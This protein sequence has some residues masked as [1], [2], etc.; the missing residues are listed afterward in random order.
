MPDVTEAAPEL[1]LPSPLVAASERPCEEKSR[2]AAAGQRYSAIGE[3]PAEP[4][5]EEADQLLEDAGGCGCF[6]WRHALLSFVVGAVISCHIM[7]M[8]YVH[9][10]REVT[11]GSDNCSSPLP[12]GADPDIDDW[13]DD[14]AK[15]TA[16]GWNLSGPSSIVGEW[17]L[18]C[19]R[20]WLVP[21]SDSL[22][23]LGWLLGGVFCGRVGD[24]HG[25][26]RP[27]VAYCLCCAAALAAT[28]ATRHIEAFI[29]CK[30]VHGFFTG[31]VLLS[32]Y[33]YGSE[34]VPAG[35]SA[36]H[37]TFYF[38]CAAAG[39]ATLAA[40]AYALRDSWRVFSLVLSGATVALIPWPLFSP[41]SPLW[42]LSLGREAEARA[43]LA[44]VARANGAPT[45]SRTWSREDDSVD[46]AG[47]LALFSDP[48]IRRITLSM[49]FVWLSASLC[50]FGLGL[51]GATLPGDAYVNG[52][53]LSVAELPV[54][55]LQLYCVDRPRLG[56]K[57]TMIGALL[58]GALAC[59]PGTLLPIGDAARW[60]AF[61]GNM[62][63]TAAF[64]TT[65]I[66]AAE[67][68]PADVRA[69]G[70]GVCT[71]GGKLGSVAT[72]FVVYLGAGSLSLAMII[73]GAVA[74]AGSLVACSLPETFG[75]VLP[76]TLAQLLSQEAGSP[77]TAKGPAPGSRRATAPC[78]TTRPVSLLPLPRRPRSVV[79]VSLSA[80]RGQRDSFGHPWITG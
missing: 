69:S 29:L 52:A 13:C 44:V 59:C 49:A 8:Y 58:V 19:G 1:R 53:L 11:C 28:A 70:L 63:M 72:P 26:R 31:P 33:V 55:P 30:F 74:A 64:T 62:F 22:F 66:W 34:F 80:A 40:V 20:S 46:D 47:A 50:Y 68:F 17:E 10:P 2:V 65:Y 48:R 27:L 60:I 78:G 76:Q 3:L 15:L 21:L 56:R 38:M 7:A 41:E 43:A 39:S 23:F 32:S 51:S 79:G 12:D 24:V 18:D 71:A 57:G 25:R 45:P 16:A 77:E 4:P 37:G 36:A 6:Q 14:P 75:V 5:A 73:F 67:T 61:A 42:L 35:R 54:Y 9:L